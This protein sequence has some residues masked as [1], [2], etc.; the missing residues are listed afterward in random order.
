MH[1]LKI[2]NCFVKKYQIK[3]Q[4]LQNAYELD[5]LPKKSWIS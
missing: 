1:L 2:K 4:L 5:Y 3:P